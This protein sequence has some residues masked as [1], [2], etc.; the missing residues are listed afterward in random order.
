[1]V[2]AQNMRNMQACT[3]MSVYIITTLKEKIKIYKDNLTE[4][5]KINAELL[6]GLKAIKHD[7]SEKKEDK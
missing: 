7:K 2:N 5:R 1:M 4:Q 6:E 3:T